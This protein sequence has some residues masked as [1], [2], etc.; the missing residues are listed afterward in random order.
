MKSFPAIIISEV[1]TIKIPE[2][3]VTTLTLKEPAASLVGALSEM[4]LASTDTVRIIKEKGV[5]KHVDRGSP[6]HRHNERIG[7]LDGAII[8]HI[9]EVLYRVGSFRKKFFEFARML[10][11]NKIGNIR[12]TRGSDQ[13]RHI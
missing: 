4:A 13:L 11:E 3:P 12:H 7:S 8:L 6:S 9:H 1:A 10:L 2:V 5:W